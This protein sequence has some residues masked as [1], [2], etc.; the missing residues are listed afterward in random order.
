MSETAINQSATPSTPS[1]HTRRIDLLFLAAPALATLLLQLLTNRGYGYFRDE[2]YYVAC[3]NHLDFGYVDHPPLI[4]LIARLVHVTLGDSLFALRLLPALTNAALVLV[5][6]L[7]A[8]QMGGGRFAQLLAG[9]AAM[10]APVYLG[11]CSFLSMNCFDL[12]IWAVAMYVIVLLLQQET[13]KRWLALGAVVGVGLEN[14]NSLLFLLFGLLVGLLLTPH[15]KWLLNK[16]LWIA[17]AVAVAIFLPNILWEV[18]HGWPTVEFMRNA[19]LYKNAPNTPVKFFM[20]QVLY[21]HP[22]ALPLWVGGLCYLLFHCEGARYR[23]LGWIYVAIFV[24]FVSTNAKAYYLAPAYPALTAAGALAAEKL[25]RRRAGAV[26]R[27]A[28]IALLLIGGAITAPLA[29]PV[30]APETFIRYSQALGVTAPKEERGKPSKLPQTYA[31]R[32]GW[33]EMV[34]KVAR[35]YHNLPAAEQAHCAIFAQNYGE[36]G[37]VDFFG[38]RYGLPPAICGHNNYYLWGPREYSG[39]VMIVI[40]GHEEDLRRQFASYERVDTVDNEYAMPFETD[41]P[42]YVCHGMKQPLRAIWPQLKG[43]M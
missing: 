8:R 4:G 1:H 34:A 3:G 19:T 36:A 39:A 13:P 33:E 7:I 16:W 27:P 38:P 32:F 9:T 29:L 17:A 25:V 35:A 21:L 5:I 41:L 18:R 31:D 28:V 14:K 11:I 22:F 43:Y 12:L 6:A 37:A 40:G 2:L 23:V 24:L 15:R 26:L 42:I 20:E 10:V 30:L